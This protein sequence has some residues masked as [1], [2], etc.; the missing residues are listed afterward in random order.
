MKKELNSTWHEFIE[1]C[2]SLNSIKDVEIFFDTFLTTT[3]KIEFANRLRIIKELLLNQKTQ[4]GI[5]K[6]LQV[7][8]A[9]VT[10]GSNVLKTSK[11]DLKK[12]LKIV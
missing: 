7:S 12:L 10:R 5:A 2:H 1:Q 4:R 6:D 3:E 11:H 9:N 8:L